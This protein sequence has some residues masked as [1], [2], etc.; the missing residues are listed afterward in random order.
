[1]RAST[2]PFTG[3]PRMLAACSTARSGQAGSSALF[4]AAQG[5]MV[6]D[7]LPPIVQREGI[8][9][10][11][12]ERDL[13]GM[14]TYRASGEWTWGAY[15]RSLTSVRCWAYFAWDDPKP[16]FKKIRSR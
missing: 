16:F 7:P 5:M 9:W 3:S 2:A 11:D 13:L 6:G 1:M 15:V 10:L 8:A 14:A 4:A 12:L